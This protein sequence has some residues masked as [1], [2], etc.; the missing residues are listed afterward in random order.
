MEKFFS[1]K[2]WVFI[3]NYSIA[4]YL[5]YKGNISADD[6]LLITTVTSGLYMGTNALSKFAIKEVK[7]IVAPNDK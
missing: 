5:L 4:T 6:W 1:R 7:D 3:L 2:L